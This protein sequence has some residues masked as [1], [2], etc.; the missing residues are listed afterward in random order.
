MI[1]KWNNFINLGLRPSGLFE[2][3]DIKTSKPTFM[4][5]NPGGEEIDLLVNPKDTPFSER[6]KSFLS[7]LREKRIKSLLEA[8]ASK[9]KKKSSDEGVNDDI[10]IPTKTKSK[11]SSSR[12]RA[13]P[14]S[15]STILPGLSPELSAAIAMSL[16]RK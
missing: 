16:T 10:P 4:K 8:R 6:P 2:L 12:T 1:R 7:D 11:R 9:R 15:I 14:T 13:I 5:F 3:V